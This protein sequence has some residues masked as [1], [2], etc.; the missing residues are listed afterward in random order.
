L[1]ANSTWHG[2]SIADTLRQMSEPENLLSALWD[3]G[4]TIAELWGFTAPVSRGTSVISEPHGLI[5]GIL[6]I[7]EYQ[8]NIGAGH[9]YLRQRISSGDWVGIGFDEKTADQERLLI[10]PKIADAKFGRRRSAVGDGVA[11]YISVRFVHQQLLEEPT[12]AAE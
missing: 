8:I 6:G 11:N 12:S 9:R 7:V 5:W 10:V 2:L 4:Y 3:C 1:A